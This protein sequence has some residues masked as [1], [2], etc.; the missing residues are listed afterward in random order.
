MD[1]YSWVLIVHLF[2][3]IIFIGFVF[4]D[5]IVFPV[6]L[7]GYPKEEFEK[8]KALVSSR[9]VKIFPASLLLLFLTGG[10][11]FSKHINSEA[12]FFS[13]SLQQLLWLKFILAMLIISGVVYSLSCKVR[14]VAPNE[15]MKHFHKFVLVM[16]IFIII[17]AK[18]MFA[19]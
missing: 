10:Y 17:L 16:G 15:K 3:A 12:G 4:A 7:K 6:I 13:T 5:V 9:A 1:T 19:I 8:I 18:A 11:M 14:K 2:C